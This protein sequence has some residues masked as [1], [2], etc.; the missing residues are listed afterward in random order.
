MNK[1]KI[2]ELSKTIHVIKSFD[3][4]ITGVRR[5]AVQ[6]QVD[7]FKQSCTWDAPVIGKEAINV[8]LVS[9]NVFH[10]EHTYGHPSLFKPSISEVLRAIPEDLIGK[11]NAVTVT[12][13]GFNDDNSKHL[14]VIKL[15]KV[16]I[17]DVTQNRFY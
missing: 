11:F 16:D 17:V 13:F 14:S 1:E 4:P 12:R 6:P 8:E 7:P 2:I 5:Y 3:D 15:Y 9:D 10:G